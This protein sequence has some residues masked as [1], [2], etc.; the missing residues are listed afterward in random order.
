MA[1]SNP[2]ILDLGIHLLRGFATGAAARKSGAK[3]RD[4]QQLAELPGASVPEAT[5]SELS[6]VFSPDALPATIISQIDAWT[7]K[8]AEY[9]DLREFLVDLGILHL[10][11][12]GAEAEEEDYF[13]SEEWQQMET[14]AE[15]RGTELPNLLIYLKDCRENQVEP[16]LNDF[17]NEFL[18]VSEDNTQDEF[19]YYEP[20][21][22]NQALVEGTAREI[23]DLGNGQRD[24]G[25]REIFTPVMLFFKDRELKPGPL[26]LA[27]LNHSALPEIHAAVYSVLNRYYLLE[28]INARN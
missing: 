5:R 2:M 25:M 6:A 16:S 9:E 22:R 13:E 27:I 3:L 19:F 26:M 21:I 24:E 23:I 11:M 12:Q 7:D 17:L 10:M 14:E 15:D 8:H 28:E 4:A 18:L 1:V 20:L